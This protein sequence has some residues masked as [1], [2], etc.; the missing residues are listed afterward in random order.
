MLQVEDAH[1]PVCRS[2]A[3][4][5]LAALGEDDYGHVCAQLTESC[6]QRIMVLT[7]LHDPEPVLRIRGD[8][9]LG[10]MTR[11]ELIQR[12]LSDGWTWMRLPRQK[13]RRQN[14]HY[15]SGQSQT[16][17]FR[18]HTPPQLSSLPS[19]CGRDL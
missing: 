13:A 5:G 2:L 1:M 12:L 16:L 17:L 19:E 11:W 14:L 3:L 4:V 15:P 6:L 9:S 10:Q 18:R 7:S 8:L